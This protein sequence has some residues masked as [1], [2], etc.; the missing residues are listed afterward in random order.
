MP[1]SAILF[2][3]RRATT[4]PLVYEAYNWAH[5]VLIGASLSSETTAAATG[6]VGKLRHDPFAMLPFCG[7]NMGD[8]FGH[9]LEMGQKARGGGLPRI[10]A[11]NWFRKSSS[12]KY[13]WPGF[14]ENARVLKWIFERV[15]G[16]EHAEK[17]PIGFVPKEEALDLKGLSIDK[18]EL[19]A[20]F[21]VD[22]KQWFKEVEEIRHYLSQFKE[23]LPDALKK[24]MLKLE[25]RLKE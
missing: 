10:Y 4:V 7:Y 23:H 8:Y 15:E 2:G 13:L 11:V 6:E 17:T 1:I 21:H 9:W 14:S 25:Q 24:E 16:M 22:R 12:G 18:E 20:L 3:G 19:N 5:G